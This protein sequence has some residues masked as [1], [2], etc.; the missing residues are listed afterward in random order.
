[1]Y[2]DDFYRRPELYDLEYQ[3]Q[4]EDLAYYQAL[5]RSAG[6]VLEL[7]AG[8]GRVTLPM[9]S[10]GASVVAV[11]LSSA[12]LSRLRSRLEDCSLPIEVVHGD[13]TELTL[14]RRFPLVV[15]AFNTI[16]HIHTS[17]EIL[18]V[19]AVVKAHLEPGGRFALDLLVPDPEF[20]ARDPE[21]I[22]EERIDED[23]HSGGRMR[24]WENGWYDEITQINHVHYHFQRAN[25]EL[26]TIHMPMRMY[27]PQEFLYLARRAGFS[28]IQC[29]GDFKGTP[30]RRGASKMA[31][32][33]GKA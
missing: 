13:F 29:D 10:T 20:F 27:Y 31:L 6:R 14:D 23:P 25:G 7:G 33:F 9:A 4:E 3:E 1:M 28:L 5:A 15:M 18:K 19:F 11:D 22:Y 12:M 30:L 8:S 32:V 2:H 24:S 17:E 26:Q 21:G 16:H